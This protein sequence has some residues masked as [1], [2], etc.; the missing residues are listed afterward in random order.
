MKRYRAH[1]IFLLILLVFVASRFVNLDADPPPTKWYGDI[2][3][4]GF[5]GAAPRD[6]VLFGGWHFDDYIKQHVLLIAPL[7]YLMQTA[8][9]AQ[10]GV[11]LVQL[12]LL[13]A[14]FGV[15]SLILLYWFIQRK[16]KTVA[17]LA[18]FF[19]TLNDSFFTYN[20]IN[21]IETTLIFFIILATILFILAKDSK[22]IIFTSGFVFGTA[23]LV[24]ISGL[25]FILA[26]LMLYAISVLRKQIK[27]NI[28]NHMINMFWFIF[29]AFLAF[30]ALAIFFYA[31]NWGEFST[32]Y[33]AWSSTLQSE[34][35]VL[36]NIF[37]LV[38]SPFFASFSVT[39]LFF[40]S[41]LFLLRF[42]KDDFQNAPDYIIFS[43]ALFFAT[44]IDALF[45]NFSERR[46]VPLLIPLAIL[47]AAQIIK[48]PTM[49]PTENNNIG[50]VILSLFI[51][52]IA[53][54]TLSE[55]GFANYNKMALLSFVLMS[56]LLVA[57]KNSAN[58]FFNYGTLILCAA[59]FILFSQFLKLI[60][61]NIFAN[62]SFVFPVAA[63]L[64]SMPLI[65][66]FS[67]NKKFRTSLLIAYVL[68]NAALIGATLL[69]PD[70][71]I[72][73]A[74]TTIANIAGNDIVTG[75]PT[76][77]LSYAGN[78]TALWYSPHHKY[79]RN[80]NADKKETL[81]YLLV[82]QDY[83]SAG[84]MY[85]R[86]NEINSTHIQSISILR[87]SSQYQIYKIT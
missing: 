85:L 54:Q 87:N 41:M 17:L 2:G 86:P 57:T 70:Y 55:L 13:P 25:H 84:Y 33:A 52:I 38:A 4:E 6:T 26:L 78:Y 40:F 30:A 29:G 5:W 28:K 64:A 82:R 48:K 73:D 43:I 12:R 9:F 21:F 31:P 15:L 42:K 19:L 49:R 47:A 59:W 80:I 63:S 67:Y 50:A 74:S 46:F 8:V 18:T 7:Y 76:Y 34:I 62:S 71:S 37:N 81:N 60:S 45:S 75:P 3:E 10:F 83:K 14:I 58:K 23:V 69:Y 22:L 39:V 72:R 1:I 20:R 53:Q 11:G 27:N 56:L 16:S 24:K 68:F 65:Y 77:H 51:A 32:I 36:E 61:F 44:F 79:F 66:G 35:N